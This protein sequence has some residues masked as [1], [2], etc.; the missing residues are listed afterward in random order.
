MAVLG[1]GDVFHFHIGTSV[2]TACRL[3]L[4]GLAMTARAN[5][6]HNLPPRKEEPQRSE[7]DVD[8]KIDELSRAI[9]LNPRDGDAYRS[10]GLLYGR[11]EAD[12]RALSDFNSALSLNPND[13]RSYAFRALVWQRKGENKRAVA[14][15]DNAIDLDPAN[16]AVYRAHRDNSLARA[17]LPVNRQQKR[18]QVHMRAVALTCSLTPLYCYLLI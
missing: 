3:H 4:A 2:R 10:R 11:K 15:F 9:K 13:A 8:R 1:A 5:R 14:D 7:V 6:I 18:A 16:A 17:V 12:D